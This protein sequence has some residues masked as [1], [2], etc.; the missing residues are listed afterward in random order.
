MALISNIVAG[1]GQYLYRSS[2]SPA[3]NLRAAFSIMGRC[4]WTSTTAS[5]VQ[6]VIAFSSTAGTSGQFL[7]RL[8]SGSDG[9][10]T[11]TTRATRVNTSS[12]FHKVSN[13]GSF[14]DTTTWRHFA[15]TYDPAGSGTI[16]YYIDGASVG[17]AAS[18]STHPANVTGAMWLG[19]LRGKT[20]DIAFF[21]RALSG[22]EV[23]DMAAY[24]V[25]QVTSGLVAFY[26]LDSNGN[27]S[28]GNGN[29]VSNA[30]SG[31]AY[32]FSTADNPPQPETPPLPLAGDAATASALS[33]TL[34]KTFAVASSGFASA[35]A[36]SGAINVNKALAGGAATASAL[37][38]DVRIGKAL[39]G[40]AA[41]ASALE[42][43]IRPRWGR[44]VVAPN[45]IDRVQ[46]G[47]IP[48]AVG[49]TMMTWFKTIAGGASENPRFRMEGL[50]AGLAS[51]GAFN[52]NLRIQYSIGATV[53]NYGVADDGNWHHMAITYDG[54]TARGYLDGSQVASGAAAPTNNFVTFSFESATSAGAAEFAHAKAWS[55]ALTAGEIVSESTYYTPHT[56]NASLYAWWQLSWQNVTLD[57][58]GNGR[59]LTDSGSTEA[60]SESPGMPMLLLSG[61]AASA[62][63]LSGQL[64][65]TQPLLGSAASASALA[66]TLAVSVALAGGA[67]TASALSGELHVAKPVAGDAAAASALSGT[68]SQT[69]PLVGPAASASALSGTLTQIVGLAGGAASASALAG[70]LGVHLPIAGGA[71]TASALSGTLGVTG[72]FAGNAHSGSMLEGTLHVL[73][74]VA[75]DAASASALSGVLSQLQPL[76][77]SAASGS[78]LSGT[79]SVSLNVPLAGGAATASSLSGSLGLGLVLSGGAVSA[80]QL[81]AALTVSQAVAGNAHSASALSGDLR[82]GKA[83]VGPAA[84]ASAMSGTLSVVQALAGGMHSGSALSGALNVDVIWYLNGVAWS[85][86]YLSGTLTVQHTA[87]ASGEVVTSGEAKANYSD[88]PI[89]SG[90]IQRRWP[91]RY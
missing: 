23:A 29:T 66:G 78:E 16:T 13:T 85:A 38:G 88:G 41:T 71:A 73:R 84:S 80:S 83:L 47:A 27:D 76:T 90:R 51:V 86:S 69:Q 53:F 28:S 55:K 63:A 64:S 68:L 26:R 1:A 40:G 17:T 22:S 43:W 77:G 8:A 25:P 10:G 24:R 4:K 9:E 57:S 21:N 34:T 32:S 15:M 79:L 65:Q 12:V 89:P 5:G 31:T 52:G 46:A 82:V 67:S 60:Q 14:G 62:S 3:V 20:A 35:S 70:E 59:T 49:W 61:G 75:G 37:T 81:S 54:T 39:A 72:A 6:Y 48:A 7:G 45:K 44:R 87:A 11:N 58:S 30:G 91:P 50:G 56:Q 42:A 2:T 74:Q 18:V 33:G 36:L 19:I